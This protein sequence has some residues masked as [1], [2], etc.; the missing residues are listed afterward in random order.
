M[1][2]HFTMYIHIKIS[3]CRSYV[4]FCQ[5]YGKD[6]LK[7]TSI[8][9]ILAYF[10]FLYKGLNSRLSPQTFLFLIF[11]QGLAKLLNFL[12]WV[13]T[14]NPLALA[15]HSVGITGMCHCTQFLSLLLLL[16]LIMFFA[17]LWFPKILLLF[18][19]KIYFSRASLRLCNLLLK[20]FQ[21]KV[22]FLFLRTTQ[23]K[24]FSWLEQD[25]A[26]SFLEDSENLQC[27]AGVSISLDFACTKCSI[28]ICST[29]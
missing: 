17:Y 5:L 8:L 3:H 28:N 9:Q 1:F 14:L 27:M 4:N 2:K 15:S 29:E 22:V 12:G 24:Q 20:S 13:Q 23:L 11:S 19:A 26:L 10:F 7:K 21:V 16:V 6:S 18:K 25:K